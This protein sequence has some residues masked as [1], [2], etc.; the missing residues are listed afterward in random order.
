MFFWGFWIEIVCCVVMV[1]FMGQILEF[2]K[3]N[4]PIAISGVK[5]NFLVQLPHSLTKQFNV[6][7]LGICRSALSNVRFYGISSELLPQNWVS[8]I[9][10]Q[11]LQNV[12]VLEVD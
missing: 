8:E 7:F 12:V 10:I 4:Q 9:T 2:P 11:E 1:R 5:S 6:V 3:Y